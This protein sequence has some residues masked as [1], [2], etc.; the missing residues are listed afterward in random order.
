MNPGVWLSQNSDIESNELH[1]MKFGSSVMAV[2]SAV[3]MAAVSKAEVA[4][5]PRL[6]CSA[7]HATTESSSVR[8]QHWSIVGSMT[9]QLLQ[10]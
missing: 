4:A 9:V 7:R 2:G 10:M 1:A 8:V 3:V 6:R 5:L